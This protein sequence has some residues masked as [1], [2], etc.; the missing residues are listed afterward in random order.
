[1]KFSFFKKSIVSDLQNQLSKQVQHINEASDFI[2]EIQKGN[3]SAPVSSELLSTPFGESLQSI[4]QHLES[5]SKEEAARSW[6]NV[7][8]ASF[9]DL[10]RNKK[11]LALPELANEILTNL[12]RHVDANQGG[13]FL[14]QNDAA[15]DYLELIA[16]YAYE[17]KKYLNKRIEIGEG[18]VGQCVLEK[19]YIY[20]KK[21]PPEYVKITSGLGEST[22][23]EI[24]I[25]PLL[26][27]DQVF[28]VLE[29][30][31]F[32][33]F[34]ESKINFINRLAE[35]IAASIKTVKETDHTTALLNESLQQSEILK[36]QEEEMRQNME[37]LQ[38]TQ[39]Q[40]Q[41]RE[42]EQ[43]S[44]IKRL[45]ELH[46]ANAA[47]YKRLSIVADNTDNSVIITDSDGY[48]EYVNNGFTSLTGYALHEVMGRKPG[49]FLQGPGTDAETVARI[50]HNLKINEAFYEE[51]LNYDKRGKEYWISLA[52]NPVMENGVC[53]NYISVQANVTETKLKSLDYTYQLD[54]IS[55]SNAVVEFNVNGII[56]SANDIFLNDT[57]YTLE[58]VKGKHHRMFV[59]E[60]EAASK[61]YAAMWTDLSKGKSLQGEFQRK[62]KD[63]IEMW[64][65]GTYTAILDLKGN[66]YKI[67]KFASNI[68]DEKKRA[69]D[70]E[71]QA[72]A[73]DNTMA[74]IEFTVNGII[75][76][77]NQI[78]LDTMKYT[79]DEVA[80]RHHQ[81]FVDP[82]YAAGSEYQGFWKKLAQGLPS[83]GEFRRIDKE[84][85]TVWL[86]ATY[87]PIKDA[88][89]KIY[90]IIKFAQ[91]I[92]G[93]KLKSID[94]SSQL[95]AI[96]KTMACIEFDTDGVIQFANQNFLK[97]M[98]YSASEIIGKHHSVFLTVRERSDVNYKAFWRELGSGKP[99]TGEFKRMSKTGTP[100]WISASYTPIKDVNGKVYKI[101]KFAQVITDQKLRTLDFQGQAEAIN[102]TMALIEFDV[103][104]IICQANERFLK[105]M[106]YTLDQIKGKH[107]RMFV[108]P[109]TASSEEYKL[110]WKALAEGKSKSGDFSRITST[111]KRVGLSASYTPIKDVQGDVY[112]IVKFA[113]DN[114]ET[115]ASAGYAEN[116]VFAEAG[117]TETLL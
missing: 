115:S 8:L 24:F 32:H 75:V 95:Q 94:V 70:F 56:L 22:P 77:A 69:L 1:M 36:S 109:E 111:G 97:A 102:H 84:K 50:R 9:S 48:I 100:V 51:I 58:E 21:T 83:Q 87:T 85:K 37:E 107:H 63:G 25:A 31:S 16:C 105:L 99:K 11:S 74:S 55:R 34:N 43:A 6:L 88:N 92:T 86:S 65:K 19:E 61:E 67:I 44:E 64:L 112:K 42:K 26:I 17:R 104:G 116:R 33:E 28:G 3:L 4:K 82:E 53:T 35:N 110:F 114:E 117:K 62:R 101:V 72:T 76:S 113:I 54:A 14:I 79:L 59:P 89:G 10:L 2:H 49:S 7:G 41:R 47:K 27:N 81:I 13:I 29:L 66:P 68:T 106:G 23:R 93:Q 98:G 30:A 108:D 90:K 78:F 60:K 40:I 80:G 73:I 15:G 20:L 96:D 57:G 38:A 12:V 71:G 46:E 18:L 5:V 45:N 91:N 39:E 52:I 103:E